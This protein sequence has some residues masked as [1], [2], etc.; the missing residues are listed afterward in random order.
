MALR[1]ERGGGRAWGR[2][3]NKQGKNPK[4]VTLLDIYPRADMVRHESVTLWVATYLSQ[5]LE[6]V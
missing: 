4:D 3:P 2:I 1:C 6:L 5:I